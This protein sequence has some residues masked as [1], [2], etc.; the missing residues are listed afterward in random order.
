MKIKKE[1]LFKTEKNC[2][3]KEKEI[4]RKTDQ[5]NRAKKTLYSPC[6]IVK[7]YLVRKHVKFYTIIL[8]S[9]KKKYNSRT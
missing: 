7:L 6:K 3:C 9:W 5:R 8:K 2:F 1:V 4:G